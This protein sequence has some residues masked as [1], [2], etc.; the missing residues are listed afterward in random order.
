MDAQSNTP[1]ILNTILSTL[2]RL[3]THLEN[4]DGR[5]SSI[6][7]SMLSA[8]DA[9]PTTP[10]ET[11]YSP[12][13][14]PA[15]HNLFHPIPKPGIHYRNPLQEHPAAAY[16]ASVMKLRSRFEVDSHSEFG[17]L[18]AEEK[19][20][21]QT[22]ADTDNDWCSMSIY[23]SR[24]LSCLRLDV[25][26]V[27]SLPQDIQQTAQE[28]RFSEYP[29]GSTNLLAMRYEDAPESPASAASTSPRDSCSENRRSTST[30]PTSIA[31]DSPSVES[32]RSLDRLESPIRA[33]MNR[34]VSLRSK[35]KGKSSAELSTLGAMPEEPSEVVT[36][37][38]KSSIRV[39]Q[40]ARRTGKA[41]VMFVPNVV[42]YIGRWMITQQLKMLD[43][44]A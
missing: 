38:E 28:P 34:S 5:L 18:G 17:I 43:N 36:H 33:L 13:H 7:C 3:E 19:G 6:E 22:I 27:P 9:Y 1:E 41:C 24:P 32:K 20:Q 35:N 21:E 15:G 12:F 42:T 2:Q 29:N 37:T 11:M 25:P 23:S 26:P 40:V 10:P 30:A 44:R 31:P 8:A 16:M 14:T 4:H 39:Y